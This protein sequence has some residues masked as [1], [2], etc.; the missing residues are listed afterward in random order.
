VVDQQVLNRVAF[1]AAC[2]M[3]YR[4]L[5][6]IVPSRAHEPATQVGS[7]TLILTPDGYP[8]I[9]TAWHVAEDANT[10]PISTGHQLCDGG[11]DDAAERVIQAP[12]DLDVGVLVPK[13]KAAKV[14]GAFGIPATAV[15]L[16]TDPRISDN[17]PC[18]LGGYPAA[19]EAKRSDH[20]RRIR[21][22]LFGS[23]TFD[24]VIEGR[25]DRGRFKLHWEER[26]FASPDLPT[27]FDRIVGPELRAPRVLP[28][29]NGMSGG[30]LWLFGVSPADQ[31][32]SPTG[33]GKL[34]GV[35]SSWNKE[36]TLFAE[37]VSSWG[38]WFSGVLRD[39][40]EQ[41]SRAGG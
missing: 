16:P 36:D 20:V 33:W 2:A 37:S 27:P 35:Q 9:L 28:R 6:F 4:S 15:A 12:G 26:S 23:A 17:T 10:G 38:E 22:Q 14:L 32:W 40:D 7:G 1:E 19:F 31:V 24:C 29:P 18:V 3:V 11:L 8:V 25:D 41:R 13:P 34:I 39:V 21:Y 30:A 5:V